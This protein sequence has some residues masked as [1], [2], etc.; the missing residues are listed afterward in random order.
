LNNHN[1]NTEPGAEV[2][3]S[4]QDYYSTVDKHTSNRNHEGD[5]YPYS[6]VDKVAFSQ[7]IELS[8][9]YAEIDKS[10]KVIGIH[11]NGALDEVKVLT[12]TYSAV[13]KN[14]TIKQEKENINE[15]NLPNCHAISE[16]YAKIDK[17]SKKNPMRILY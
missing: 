3:T 2:N 10:V 9:I 15:D 17:K 1:S 6:A 5:H 7:E 8:Q 4:P 14:S 16:M 11:F 12:Q 13:D